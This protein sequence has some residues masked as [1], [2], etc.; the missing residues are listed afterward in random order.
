MN[1]Y[2]AIGLYFLLIIILYCVIMLIAQYNWTKYME[3]K[4]YLYE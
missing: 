4:E 1:K 3:N 2:L